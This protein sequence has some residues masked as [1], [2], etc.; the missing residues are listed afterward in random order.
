MKYHKVQY[1]IKKYTLRSPE[2]KI[3]FVEIR[4]WFVANCEKYWNTSICLEL[5]QTYFNIPLLG[6]DDD[7]LIF[8]KEVKGAT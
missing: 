2:C 1:H 5:H 7:S 6:D 3:L 8:E 4:A